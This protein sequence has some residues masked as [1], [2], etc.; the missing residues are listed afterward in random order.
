MRWEEQI[1]NHVVMVESRNRYSV[2]TCRAL[3]S[4]AV[5]RRRCVLR[6]VDLSTWVLRS[7]SRPG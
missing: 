4:P 6:R 7:R 1:E 3:M 2:S 5:V